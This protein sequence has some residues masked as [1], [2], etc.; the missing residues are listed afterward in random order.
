MIVEKLADNTV[1]IRLTAEELERRSLSIEAIDKL[2]AETYDPAYGA[3]VKTVVSLAELE[4]GMTLGRISISREIDRETNAVSFTVEGVD[5]GPAFDPDPQYADTRALTD[6][7]QVPGQTGNENRRHKKD[8][9]LAG[10]GQKNPQKMQEDVAQG[11]VRIPSGSAAATIGS[12]IAEALFK[13]LMIDGLMNAAKNIGRGRRPDQPKQNLAP[14]EPDA[15]DFPF[16]DDQE[17]DSDA[18]RQGGRETLENALQYRREMLFG[19]SYERN[20]GTAVVS[21]G[22]YD[23]LYDFVKNHP[24]LGKM[25]SSL[26]ELRSVFYLVLEASRANAGLLT[27]IE[28]IAA[29][30]KGILVPSRVT[31]PV[32]KE[33]GTKY[34]GASA[35]RL[36]SASLEQKW[37]E[38]RS[39]QGRDPDGT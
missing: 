17:Q 24:F 10:V 7:P 13:K 19:D 2:T 4:L 25:R 38:K 32:L 35:V 15:S 34:F 31:L 8:L 11:E 18:G 9:P 22:L 5:A 28:A 26:Y 21:F 16:D 37:N 29:E 33:Y 1:R 3:L 6:A 14:D 27:D 36:I 23:E 30:Y 20:G 39:G 12:A